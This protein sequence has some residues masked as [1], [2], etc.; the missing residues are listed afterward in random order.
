MTTT[1]PSTTNNPSNANNPNSIHR[2]SQTAAH[3]HQHPHGFDPNT[4]KSVTIRR[5]SGS[6]SLADAIPVHNR[7]IEIDG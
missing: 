6:R 1:T 3:Q 4:R 7:W 5:R 2:K